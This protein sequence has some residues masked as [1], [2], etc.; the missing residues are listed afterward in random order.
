MTRTSKTVAAAVVQAL[1]RRAQACGISPAEFLERTGLSSSEIADPAARIGRRRFTPALALAARLRL[2]S[3]PGPSLDGLAQRL[4]ILVGTWL[5]APTLRSALDA[6]VRFRPLLGESD[7]VILRMREGEV[8]IEYLADDPQEFAAFQAK[9]NFRLLVQ[10]VRN[11]VRGGSLRF[12]AWL[13]EDPAL[14]DPWFEALLRGRCRTG[15]SENVLQFRTDELDV[16]FPGHNAAL[17][18]INTRHLEAALDALERESAFSLRTERAIREVL[19]TP[20][21]TEAPGV[22]L[23]ELC[24]GLGL[25]RTTLRRKL[26]V[27]GTSF[28]RLW[29]TVRAQE[30]Q[31]LL[32]ETSLSLGEI[33][34]RLGFASQSS[35]TRFFQ[36]EV[37]VSP[38]HYRRDLG[39]RA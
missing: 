30:A 18:R 37:E 13:T 32:D 11:Y 20:G 4:P 36:R 23:E 22:L 33:S 8:R 39:S 29:T 31:R 3:E 10:V 28:Q 17:A 34:D 7:H 25:S 6:F 26:A 12:S 38:L 2:P 35:F 21:R 14:A 19:T 1:Q 24:A 5:N 27:E 16:P 15:Q 9:A